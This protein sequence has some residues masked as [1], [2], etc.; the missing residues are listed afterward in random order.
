MRTEI[1]RWKIVPGVIVVILW[2][3]GG[4]FPLLLLP[5]LYVRLVEHKGFH[6]LGFS[7]REIRS[8]MIGGVA[9]ALALMGVYYP[10]FLSYFSDSVHGDAVDLYGVLLDVLWYPVYEETAYR[11]FT[12]THFANLDEPCL[13][14][15]NL[16]SNVA[17]SLLFLSIHKHH[18]NAPLVLVPVFLLALLNGILFVR[19]RNLF[20]CI[21]SHSLLNGFAVLLR[22]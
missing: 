14:P 6:W 13:S 15:R 22:T 5:I 12:L 2:L 4:F 19:T 17:Q 3:N 8:S 11:G 16:I 21:V 7:R 20:G 1:W 10:I 9:I 18:L